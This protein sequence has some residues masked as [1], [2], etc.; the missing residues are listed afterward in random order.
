[1]ASPSLG[2]RA[3]KIL[4]ALVTEHIETA[5]PVGSRTLSKNY[6]F[7][8]S[9]A[10]I[11]NVLSDLEEDGYLEQPHTSAGRVPTEQGLRIFVE[12]L[13]TNLHVT[14][15][16]KAEVVR[17]LSALN[18][19][20]VL[21]RATGQLL[22]A[23]TGGAAVITTLGTDHELLSELRFVP[24]RAQQVL[25][26][27]ITRGGHVDNR[28]FHLPEPLGASELERVH[29]YLSSL[30][31]GRS[32]QQLRAQVSAELE[33]E[34]GQ[35]RTL[36]QRV[37]ALLDAAAEVHDQTERLVIEGRAQLFEQPEFND[38]EKLRAM[39][40]A[41]ED[42][43]L[44]LTLIDGALSSEGVRVR[45]GSEVQVAEAPALSLISAGYKRDGRAIGTVGVIAPAR[46]DY[47]KVM[48]LVGFTADLIAN[49]LERREGL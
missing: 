22:S 5:A 44:L 3:R 46:T 9:A 37:K 15:S 41:F 1:M 7:G 16:D 45:I 38:V 47:A 39:V 30:V 36:K 28:V 4:H 25:A 21:I 42:K 29:N 17:R 19:A 20:E 26:V 48:P 27:V 10:S 13:L 12:T 49:L 6:G 2:H 14:E 35:Y 8:L 31:V 43:S 40:R 23:M 33:T 11:R 34:Q 18:S 32:L 24:V